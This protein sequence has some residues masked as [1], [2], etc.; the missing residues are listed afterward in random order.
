ME[1]LLV[2]GSSHSNI[3]ALE[4]AKGLGIH[5]IVTDFLEPE[6]SPAKLVA[7]E[8]WMISTGDLDLLEKKCREEHVSYVYAGPSEFNL[9][10]GLALTN[11]LGLPW[12]CDANA[13]HY[14]RN[15][16]DFKRLCTSAGVPVARDYSVSPNPTEEE[17]NQISFPVVVKAIDLAGNEGMSY[18]YNKE[19]LVEA[20]KL[21]RSLSDSEEIVVEKKLTGTEYIAYYALAEGKA[22][23]LSFCAM[24]NQPGYP[25]SCYSF[26]TSTTDHLDEF[27]E[28]VDPY[29]VKAFA[30]AGMNEGFCF[31]EFIR[32]EEDG[33]CALET[34]YRMTGELMAVPHKAVLGFD[35]PAW[36]MDLSLGRTHQ[37]AD[38]PPRQSRI[39]E[40]CACSY[41]L[42]SA[43]PGRVAKLE[44]LEEIQRLP[45]VTIRNFAEVGETFDQFA[46]LTILAFDSENDEEMERLIGQIND[47]IRIYNENGENMVLYYDDFEKLESMRASYGV[48]F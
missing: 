15:K 45:N 7:D 42:W 26:T 10:M 14:S 40:R 12:F 44:G 20:C 3:E 13:W 11:R 41:I 39:P 35:T 32:D 47:T 9:D 19:S 4:Y 36:L 31:V 5:T 37:A 25:L 29:L 2:F 23:L 38:L 27:L 33:F 24:L 30:L 18:C 1:K 43:K 16:A 22:S 21:A 34:G 17:L 8:Y 48:D 46:Y 28:Q 6:Q